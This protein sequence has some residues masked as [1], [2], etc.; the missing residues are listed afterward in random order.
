MMTLLA[1]NDV[2]VFTSERCI[3]AGMISVGDMSNV[4]MIRPKTFS[5]SLWRGR[6]LGRNDTNEDTYMRLDFFFLFSYCMQR[7]TIPLL[8]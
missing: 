2:H 8:H 6:L 1:S 7:L 4:C 5:L 3:Y